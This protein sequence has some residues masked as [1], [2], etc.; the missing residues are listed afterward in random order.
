MGGVSLTYERVYKPGQVERA[1][2]YYVAGCDPVRSVEKPMPYMNPAEVAR[3]RWDD[4]IWMGDP[5]LTGVWEQGGRVRFRKRKPAPAPA[6]ETE[7]PFNRHASRVRTL[8]EEA[9]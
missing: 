3:V 7:R 6:H 9:A 2:R 8:K 1:W 5:S 4:V